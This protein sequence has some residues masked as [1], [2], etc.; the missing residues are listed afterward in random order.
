MP[1][2]VAVPAIIGGAGLVQQH[3]QNKSA[4][5]QAQQQAQQYGVDPQELAKSRAYMDQFMQSGYTPEQLQGFAGKTAWGTQIG[6]YQAANV[7]PY[8]STNWGDVSRFQARTPQEQAALASLFGAGRASGAQA[9]ALSALSQ[10]QLEA[11]ARRNLA[12]LGGSRGAATQAIAPQAAQIAEIQQGA[13]RAIES[14]PGLRGA[15]REQAL[16]EASRQTAGQIGSLIPAA[17]QQAMQQTGQL[18]MGQAQLAQGAL[19]QA[20]QLFGATTQAE[21]QN[22]QFGI[23][24]EQQNR[25]MALQALLQQAAQGLEARGQDIGSGRDILSALLG[26]RGQNLEAILGRMGV[27]T[28][29]LKLGSENLQ[30]QQGYNQKNQQGLGTFLGGLYNTWMQNRGG[31]G[32]GFSSGYGAPAV[33]TAGQNLFGPGR[34]YAVTPPGYGG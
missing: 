12:L 4:Q 11:V 9:G 32:G 21:A 17:Q 8:L 3:F 1:A 13:R 34:G 5:K 31:T 10:P 2:A 7:D 6:P 18:G 20:G 19:G 28:A 16:A 26:Q 27:D 25:Q 22:R 33:N 15:A 14:R 24:A 30:F 29:R 23:G